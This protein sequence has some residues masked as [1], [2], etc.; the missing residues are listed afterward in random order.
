MSNVNLSGKTALITGST[1]GIGLACA[2]SLARAG[3]NIVLNG[4]GDA[5]EIEKIRKTIET[6][7]NVKAIYANYDLTKPKE[8]KEM[9]EKATSVFGGVDVLVNNAGMQHVQPIQDMYEIDST[10]A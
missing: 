10:N 8:I 3:A 5:A 1:S 9:I 4:F 2:H 7:Y 6:T